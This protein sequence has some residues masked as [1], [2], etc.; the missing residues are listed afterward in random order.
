MGRHIALAYKIGNNN[1]AC[2]LFSTL[3]MVDL[4]KFD[5]LARLF[6]KIWLLKFVQSK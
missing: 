4:I 5:Q 6:Q 3:H 1:I 2:R